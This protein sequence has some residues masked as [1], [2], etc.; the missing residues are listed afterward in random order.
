[1][2][3]LQY[4]KTLRLQAARRLLTTNADA[5]RAAYAVG[6]ESTS[7]FSREYARLFGAPPARDVARLRRDSEDALTPV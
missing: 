2:S 5:T 3:P 7:Q 1:M 6:Y 4:Q